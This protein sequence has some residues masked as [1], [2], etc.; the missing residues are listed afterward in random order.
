MLAE[1]IRE[2]LVPIII[3]KRPTRKYQT[4][5][6]FSNAFLHERMRIIITI[7]TRR[8]VKKIKFAT[9]TSLDS[10]KESIRKK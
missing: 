2:L 5:T 10:I 7:M 6:T 9:P 1:M 8:E 3:I 4:Q